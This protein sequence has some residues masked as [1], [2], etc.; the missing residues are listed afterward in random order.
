M[1][2]FRRRF[3]A[4]LE[5]RGIQ[6]ST[7][8]N[9]RPYDA[10]LVIGGT[11]QLPGLWWAR[12]KGIR[13]VQRLNGMNWIHRKRRTGWKHTLR[14]EYGNLLLNTIRTRFADWVVYQSKFAQGWWERVYGKTGV[15]TKVVYNA[16]DL[17]HYSPEGEEERPSDRQRVLLVE[18][19]LGGGYEQGL[20]TVDRM[21]EI[22]R[23]D[24][25]RRVEVMVVGQVPVDLKADWQER[26]SIPMVFSGK[27]PAGQI[28][29][30]DRSAH[31]L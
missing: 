9:N 20:E 26:T 7:S 13:I 2:S 10:V 29:Q 21:A 5:S 22:L 30:I 18:G 15:S 23:S 12:R 27:Q 6:V 4:G 3:M 28:P 25:G 1:V 16:V 17:Y 31:V 8:L 14:A 19:S 24:H 11:R